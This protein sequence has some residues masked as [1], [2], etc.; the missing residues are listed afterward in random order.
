MLLPLDQ[1]RCEAHVRFLGKQLS[2]LGVLLQAKQAS[3]ASIGISTETGT[4][5]IAKLSWVGLGDEITLRTSPMLMDLGGLGL[6]VLVMSASATG[7][8]GD[9]RPGRLALGFGFGFGFGFRPPSAAPGRVGK[10]RVR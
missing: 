4:N 10:V 5:K 2:Q 9:G 8:P 6:P 3:E 7:L 1:G